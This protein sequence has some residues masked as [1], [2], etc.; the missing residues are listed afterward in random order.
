MSTDMTLVCPR[1]QIPLK[2]TKMQH[3]IF[4]SC[5]NC[6]GRAV[7][8]ELL[9]RTFT[10][11]SIN[12]L[13]LHAIRGDGQSSAGCPFCKRPMLEVSLSDQAAVKVDVCKLC[14]F[15]WFDAHEVESLTPRPLSEIQHED[16]ERIAS[17]KV[18]A[19]AKKIDAA[20]FTTLPN[21]ETWSALAELFR[22]L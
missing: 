3:G 19:F 7:T 10:P 9:R 4:W 5:G 2:Q 1:C 18:K 6:G 17:E 14:H 22:G 8:V 20:Q 12:P 11:E 21:S 13:W 15:V 16:R